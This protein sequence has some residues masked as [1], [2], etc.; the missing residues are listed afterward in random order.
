L[1]HEEWLHLVLRLK[2]MLVSLT[3]EVHF[4]KIRLGGF[5]LLCHLCVK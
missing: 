2:Y 1:Y 4:C 3:V 5:L